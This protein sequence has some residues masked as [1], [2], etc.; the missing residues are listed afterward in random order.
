[1]KADGWLSVATTHT[2]STDLANLVT[3][4]DLAGQP[5]VIWAETKQYLKDRG[6]VS[7]CLST[8]YDDVLRHRFVIENDVANLHT[9]FAVPVKCTFN[10]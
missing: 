6:N 9:Q 8:L 3:V 5:H 4:I 10:C 2:N 7:Q 1:M